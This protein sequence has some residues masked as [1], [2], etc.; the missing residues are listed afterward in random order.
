MILIISGLEVLCRERYSFQNMGVMY[1]CGKKQRKRN[2]ESKY[3][4]THEFY[5]H[6]LIYMIVYPIMIN[7]ILRFKETIDHI[8]SHILVIICH[9]YIIPRMARFFN[10]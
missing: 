3:E 2:E 5:L 6:G 7:L 9:N 8:D 4:Q 1:I 10:H